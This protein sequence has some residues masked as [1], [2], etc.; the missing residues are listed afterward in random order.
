MSSPNLRSCCW[1]IWYPEISLASLP[2][3]I[4]LDLDDPSDADMSEME[5]D[6]TTNYSVSHAYPVSKTRY[7]VFMVVNLQRPEE[8]APSESMSA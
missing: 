5:P 2:P 3:L 8:D 1:F 6:L 4:R 7:N